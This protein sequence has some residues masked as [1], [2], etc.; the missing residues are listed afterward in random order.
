VSGSSFTFVFATAG[1]SLVFDLAP[2]LA[3][4]A[5]FFEV[6]ALGSSSSSLDLKRVRLVFMPVHSAYSMARL[7]GVFFFGFSCSSSLE[8]RVYEHVAT[9]GV[10]VTDSARRFAGVFFAGRFSSSESLTTKSSSP[11]LRQNMIHQ[12]ASAVR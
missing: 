2:A 12:M 8:L 5:D 6:D 7:A 10:D 1:A 11:F 9:E 3:E 4:A